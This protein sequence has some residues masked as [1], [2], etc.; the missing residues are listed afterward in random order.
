[1]S[2]KE[3][4]QKQMDFERDMKNIMLQY[5]KKVGYY[6]RVQYISVVKNSNGAIVKTL[7]PYGQFKVI[8]KKKKY[9]IEDMFNTFSSE[10]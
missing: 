7:H 9:Q 6:S 8:I 2:K 1:M 3:K 4:Q 5:F 10:I